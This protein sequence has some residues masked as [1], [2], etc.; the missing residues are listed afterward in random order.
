MELLVI[1]LQHV[2][3][4]P[5]GQLW[6]G[7]KVLGADMPRYVHILCIQSPFPPSLASNVWP[8]PPA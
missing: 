8:L 6:L 7:I 3:A 4:R 5:A 1:T 2:G